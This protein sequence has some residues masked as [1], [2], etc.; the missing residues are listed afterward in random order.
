MAV[1]VHGLVAMEGETAFAFFVVRTHEPITRSAVLELLRYLAPLIPDPDTFLEEVA[2]DLEQ[3]VQLLALPWLPP[4]AG[5]AVEGQRRLIESAGTLGVEA[6]WF[7][8][9]GT[10]L[11][12][13][14]EDDEDEETTT[15]TMR[16]T[17]AAR[18][19]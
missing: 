18:A 14:A 3:D 15:K 4:E 19:R 7:F 1:A 16:T 13:E 12:V 6:A 10:S 9:T 5:H 2:E 8:Q 17:C 11:P